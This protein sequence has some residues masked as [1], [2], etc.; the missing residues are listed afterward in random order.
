MPAAAA[1]AVKFTLDVDSQGE[2]TLQA[3]WFAPSMAEGCLTG[4]NLADDIPTRA[5]GWR[6]R[7]LHFHN[8]RGKGARVACLAFIDRLHKDQGDLGEIKAL[9]NELVLE[10][11]HE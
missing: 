4:T 7:R 3:H 6:M 9:V 2:T 8:Q 11:G 1:D 10:A 5:P